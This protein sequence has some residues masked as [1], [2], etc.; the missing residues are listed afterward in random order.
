MCVCY[1][2]VAFACCSSGKLLYVVGVCVFVLL[3][4]F[5]RCVRVC[6]L[7]CCV[8]FGGSAPCDVAVA[9]W[10]CIH[11]SAFCYLLQ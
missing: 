6:V 2:C 10:F 9:V 5:V 4:V 3:S 11:V 7:F 8:L 1:R